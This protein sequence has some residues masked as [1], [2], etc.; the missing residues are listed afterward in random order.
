MNYAEKKQDM[1][2]RVKTSLKHINNHKAFHFGILASRYELDCRYS[3]FHYLNCYA[4][5]SGCNKLYFPLT[6]S[7][8]VVILQSGFVQSTRPCFCGK[9]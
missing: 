6:F 3:A 7:L 2:E 8:I 4:K 9:S 5:A 1:K